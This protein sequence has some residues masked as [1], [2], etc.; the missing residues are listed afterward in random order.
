MVTGNVHQVHYSRND[1]TRIQPITIT[2]STFSLPANE[3]ILL[4]S[5]NNPSDLGK[6]WE[7]YD[8]T[9]LNTGI[10]PA[11]TTTNWTGG[12][13]TDFAHIGNWDAGVP[14]DT[15]NAIIYKVSKQPVVST[16]QSTK[17]LRLITGA[18]V[19]NNAI[20]SIKDSLTNRGTISGTGTVSLAGASNQKIVGIGTINTLELNNPAGATI[21]SGSN[22]TSLTGVLS[23]NS[24]TLTTNGNLTLKSSS[25]ATASI[26]PIAS[27]AGISG[28]IT[29][30]RFIPAKSARKFS[31]VSS[32]VSQLISNAWQQQIFITGSGT[33]GTICSTAN[34]NGFDKTV[35]DSP[36][37]FTC[38]AQPVN[39]SRWTRIPNTNATS[40]DAGV[41][42]KI[43]IRGSRTNGGGCSNQL[44]SSSPTAPDSVVLVATGAYN[45][46]PTATIYGQTNYVTPG[47]AYTLIGNPYP[48]PISATN[49]LVAN[50]NRISSNAWLYANS[51]NSRG[52]YGSWNRSTKISTGYWPTDFTTANAADLIIPSGSAFFVERT[53][54]L[55]TTVT[56]SEAHKLANTNS[57]ITVFGSSTASSAW[58]NKLRCTLALGDSSFIDDAVL[59]YSNEAGI[60][61]NAYTDFDTYSFNA[62]TN[63]P[64]LSMQKGN[65]LLSVCTKPFSTNDTIALSF[66]NNSTVG[67]YQFQ[68]SEYQTLSQQYIIMLYDAFLG[69]TQSIPSNPLYKFTISADSNSYSPNRFKLITRTAITL[70]INESIK[71]SAANENSLSILK[72]TSTA[73]AAIK[74]YELQQMM[75]D[76]QF[77]T[78]KNINAIPSQSEYQFENNT[79]KSNTFRIKAT[80]IANQPIFSNVVT[81]IKTAATVS[82]F[83]NPIRGNQI[84]LQLTNLPK[85]NYSINILNSV[86]KIIKRQSL[87]HNGVATIS[88]DL[89]SAHLA[90]GSYPL[91]IMDTEKSTLVCKDMLIIAK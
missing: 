63:Q 48:S 5:S 36:S 70:P 52:N 75:T 67:N 12:F 49:F 8:E 1:T 41:G 15:I 37:M 39:G 20:L 74:Q 78:I 44:N 68:F 51:N 57:G 2:S 25:L 66:Y 85:G 35:T 18:S 90:A 23:L 80:T 21:S 46:N 59:A 26:A 13:N 29:V 84:K 30:E 64:F 3:Q 50:T 17:A 32:P 83:P 53:G 9:L 87:Y 56:F 10:F 19:T 54:L 11:A 89:A 60:S 61:N 65:K 33:A 6:G 40:L 27:G 47:G 7:N 88:I 82:I 4:I 81:V 58:D 28:N 79:S 31:F 91:Y 76:N 42:Y 14:N 62:T 86:G 34:S 55:D 45:S 73:P 38:S 43:N 71:L 24:G 77:N 16:N 22:M 69:K 72:W